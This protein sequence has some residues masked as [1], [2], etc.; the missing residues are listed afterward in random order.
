MMTAMQ[1]Q[2]IVDVPGDDF[3]VEEFVLLGDP[4]LKMGGYSN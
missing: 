4:S 2:Y 1:N 3:T